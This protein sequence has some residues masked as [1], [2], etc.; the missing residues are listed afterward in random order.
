MGGAMEPGQSFGHYRIER[1]I[2]Q[3]GVGAVYLAEDTKLG[4]KVAPKV[5]PSEMAADPHRLQRFERE[6]RAVAALNHPHIVTLHTV[7]E[8]NG[9]H[10]LTMELVEGESLDRSIPPATEEFEKRFGAEDPSTC[11]QMRAWR[12]EADL[13]FAWFDR[14]LAVRDPYLASIKMD[15]LLSS[16]H[17]DPRWK[18]L[19]AKIGLPVD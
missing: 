3:G 16:L 7:E 5:L 6:A 19:L 14:A 13:A 18:P 15:P 4:R 1:V 11:A 17:G 9:T 12:G 8:Q 10:F 2:G